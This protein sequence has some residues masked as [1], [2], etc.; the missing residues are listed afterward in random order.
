[1]WVLV[2]NCAMVSSSCL[3]A[4]EWGGEDCVEEEGALPLTPSSFS[5]SVF[6]VDDECTLVPSSGSA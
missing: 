6:N 1:V 3:S 2:S 5:E 4:R